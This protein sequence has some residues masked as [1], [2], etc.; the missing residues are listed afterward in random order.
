MH[1][2]HQLPVIAVVIPAYM[3]RNHILDVLSRIGPEVAKIIVIDDACPDRSGALV[4]E[5]V[6][7]PRVHVHVHPVNLGVGGA[8]IT[9]YRMA[10]AAGAD[11]VVKVDG[12]GQ[13]P[14]EFIPALVA[15]IVTGEA[16]Y[17]KGNRFFN[18]EDVRGMPPI[19]LFGNAAL[20]LLTK[21][22]TGY[23]SIVDPTNGFT[24]VHASILPLLRLDRIA[25]RYFFESDLLFRLSLLRCRVID[26]PMAAVYRGE[27]SNLMIGRTAHIFLFAN[28]ANLAKRI[29]YN[30]FVRGFSI[31]SLYLVAA[32]PLLMFA[33]VYGTIEWVTSIETSIARPT[34]TVILVAFLALMGFQLLLAF[35][36]HDISAEPGTAIHPRLRRLQQSLAILNRHLQPGAP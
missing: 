12:D 35:G 26:V 14:P 19:R 30:Y 16:D 9:G 32:I 10:M 13:M 1:P 17:T 22:S 29:I 11:I 28:V 36:A 23:W 24:A 8:V 20:S 25:R 27:T 33:L 2:D 21:G 18:P 31:A 4:T 34:G 7:D 15:P 3:V 6:S 5:A